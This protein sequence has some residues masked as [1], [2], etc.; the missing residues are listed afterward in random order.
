MNSVTG[1]GTREEK[2]KVKLADVLRCLDA[3]DEL[4]RLSQPRKASLASQEG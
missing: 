2:V 1:I 4:L 3:T